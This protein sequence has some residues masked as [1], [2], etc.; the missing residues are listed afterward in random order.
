MGI[1][2]LLLSLPYI[3]NNN[4]RTPSAS[5]ANAS[6]QTNHHYTTTRGVGAC[7]EF[8]R[9]RE[10][11]RK[12]G[13]LVCSVPGRWRRRRRRRTG[14]GGLFYFSLKT[15][16]SIVGSPRPGHGDCGL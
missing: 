8:R 1:H 14:S 16:W 10:D 9:T 6:P 5:L 13:R 11:A 15:A 4:V 12:E 7:V 2:E 3:L